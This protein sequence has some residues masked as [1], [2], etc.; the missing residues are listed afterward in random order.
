[1]CLEITFRLEVRGSFPHS[2]SQ[3]T[4][5]LDFQIQDYPLFHLIGFLSLWIK[6]GDFDNVHQ[7]YIF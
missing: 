1:M 6:R 5:P 3:H 2:K 4:S 7:T